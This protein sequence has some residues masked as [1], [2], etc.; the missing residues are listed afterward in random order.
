M[1]GPLPQRVKCGGFLGCGSTLDLGAVEE[2]RGPR[3]IDHLRQ[4][5]GH[6]ETALTRLLVNVA[7]TPA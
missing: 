3:L 6:Q 7:F 1:S 2:L 5:P 4:H